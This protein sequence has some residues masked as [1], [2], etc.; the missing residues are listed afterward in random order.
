MVVFTMKEKHYTEISKIIKA[1][2]DTYLSDDGFLK[3]EVAF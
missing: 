3:K 1:Q 2:Y